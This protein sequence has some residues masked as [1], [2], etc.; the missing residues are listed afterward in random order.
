MMFHLLLGNE[1]SLGSDF[2]SGNCIFLFYVSHCLLGWMS[3]GPGAIILKFSINSEV[4][5]HAGQLT[6]KEM[7]LLNFC[8]GFLFGF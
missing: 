7:G 6:L 5:K 2:L 3:K 8:S 1:C 4:I